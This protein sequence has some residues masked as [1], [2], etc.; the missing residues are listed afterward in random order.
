MFK[1]LFFCLI[2]WA[3]IAAANVAGALIGVALAFWVLY[4]LSKIWNK[5]YDDDGQ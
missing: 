1:F 2:A 4:E 3:I 5:E